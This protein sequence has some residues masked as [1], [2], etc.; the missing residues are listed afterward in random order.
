MLPLISI[1]KYVC[2]YVDCFLRRLKTNVGTD[3]SH[4]KRNRLIPHLEQSSNYEDKYLPESMHSSYGSQCVKYIFITLLQCVKS[5]IKTAK[6]AQ[7]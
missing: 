7:L 5:V 6:I 3:A 2:T 1:H 4:Y